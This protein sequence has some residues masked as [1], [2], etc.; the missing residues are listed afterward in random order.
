MTYTATEWLDKNRDTMPPGVMQ[1][2]QTSENA[3]LSLIFK[4]KISR[5][6]TLALDSLQSKRSTKHVVII[7]YYIFLP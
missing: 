7:N 6:G 5:T 4:G 1:M 3:L 2:L